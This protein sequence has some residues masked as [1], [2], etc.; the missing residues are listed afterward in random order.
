MPALL[1]D[2]EL[3][4]LLPMERALELVRDAVRAAEGG[5]L[6]TPP[7]VSADLGS[8][9]LT[10]TCG[11]LEG[12]WFG[13]RSYLAPGDAGEQ[14][15]VV[16][17]DATTGRVTGAYAGELLGPLRTGAI[18][19]V[20][21]DALAPRGPVTLA[22]VGA[23]RQAWQ[24]VR[25][26]ACVREVRALTVASRGGEHARELAA[27]ARDELAVPARA[28]DS[29]RAAVEGAEVVVLATSSATPVVEVGWL[30]HARVVTTLGPK[31]VG[32][33]ELPVELLSHADRLVTDSLAQVAAYDPP[34]FVVGTPAQQRL[35]SLGS[36]L[37]SPS[38]D[39][40]PTGNPPTGNPPAPGLSVFLSV[41]L[42]G[43]EAHLLHA[44]TTGGSALSG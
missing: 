19:G 4:R 44:V 17:Q 32:R 37:D 30:R 5:R 27:R 28:V 43:T 29:V 38:T 3:E 33:H 6:R 2:A 1:A 13:Y 42:A 36:V 11:A 26:V 25:A 9:R 24:Q 16:V 21:V 31:Q 41:G 15:V 40:P 8:S 7:R 35:V 34:S 14:Q 10:F 12:E 23:G 22:L 39:S 18:G 20:A